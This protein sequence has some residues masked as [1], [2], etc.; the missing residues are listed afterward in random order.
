MTL[1][2]HR[3]GDQNSQMLK[4]FRD[5]VDFMAGSKIDDLTKLRATARAMEAM[6]RIANIR[7]SRDFTTEADATVRRVQ[8]ESCSIDSFEEKL[9]GAEAA[10]GLREGYAADLVESQR[11]ER[12]EIKALTKYLRDLPLLTP[13]LRLFI[14]AKV[15]DNAVERSAAR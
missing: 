12:E 9:R 1:S 7:V 6:G 11:L 8:G 2:S 3:L 15:S 4:N 13:E 10:G 5:I 14:I